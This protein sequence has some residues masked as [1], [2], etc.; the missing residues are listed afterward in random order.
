MWRGVVRC[1]GDR[2]FDPPRGR[3]CGEH[4]DR[5]SP[6]A[7]VRAT[8]RG[9]PRLVYEAQHPG[10]DAIFEAD[11]VVNTLV[12]EWPQFYG[13]RAARGDA[14]DLLPLAALDGALAASFSG[15]TVIAVRPH[16]WK[17]S[18]PKPASARGKYI[19][20]YRVQVRL[21]EEERR[22]ITWPTAGKLSWDV[23]DAIG[24]GLWHLGRFDRK[25]G[26][27]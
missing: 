24:I 3:V 1:P 5:E 2:A 12:V 16:Q 7:E 10:C 21:S 9:G 11:A 23:A 22:R 25:R 19:I 26:G 27:L 18:V 8:R 20:R 4:R 15:A 13:G 14:N 6:A 17:G